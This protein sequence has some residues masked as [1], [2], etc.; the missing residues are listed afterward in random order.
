M[1]EDLFNYVDTTSQTMDTS[2]GQLFS[3]AHEDE[4][5]W[6]SAW[7]YLYALNPSLNK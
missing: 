4:E 7:N 2:I 5:T 6:A 3:I 1:V